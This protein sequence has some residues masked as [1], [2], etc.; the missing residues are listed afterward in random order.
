MRSCI[1]LTALCLGTVP[2]HAG[3][4]V[5]QKAESIVLGDFAGIV[6]YTSELD[7]YRVVAT[8][9]EGGAGLPVRFVVTLAESERI[10]ISVPG[11][12]GQLSHE[13][14]ISR[15]NGK[16]IVSSRVPAGD[17]ISAGPHAFDR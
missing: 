3:E 4:L 2:V 5:A 15:E 14:D 8:I 13:V 10:T 12:L 11:Q 7:G 9:A 16:L 1:F 17:L 6:Y